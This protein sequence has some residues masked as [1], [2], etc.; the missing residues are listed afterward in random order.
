MCS[1]VPKIMEISTIHYKNGL[2]DLNKYYAI[3]PNV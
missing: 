3:F 1:K 2:E